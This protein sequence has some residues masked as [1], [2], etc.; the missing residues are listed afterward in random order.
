MSTITRRDALKL[1]S[2]AAALVTTPA[3]AAA[4]AY[5]K[6]TEHAAPIEQWSVFETAFEANSDGNPFASVTLTAS[7]RQGHR[8]L[9][10]DGF[11]DGSGRYKL[12]FM[13]DAV[14]EWSFT[15]MSSLP[16]LHG[17]QGSFHC[18]PATVG[19]HGPVRV[20]RG[21]HFG[22]ADGKPFLPFGT[23]S[24]NWAH[25]SPERQTQTLAALK[26]APFNKLRMCVFPTRFSDGHNELKLA[27][28]ERDA[29]DDFDHTRLNPLFF[30]HLEEQIVALGQQGIEADLILFHPYD[31]WGFAK[32]SAPDDDR[33]LRYVLA[34]FSAYRNV[35]WSLANE[36]DLVRSKTTADFDRFFRI[37]TSSDPYQHLRS[38]HYS[39]VMYDYAAAW[40]T[41]AS[42]QTDAFDQAPR[43][44]AD[45]NKPVLFDEVK[46]EGNVARRWGNLTGEELAHRF[47]LGTVAGCYVTH[48]ETL[49]PPDAP[50]DETTPVSVWTAEGVQLRG[51]SPEMIGFLRSLSEAVA[52]SAAVRAG[53]EAQANPYYLNATTYEADGKTAHA[54]LWYFAE[55]QPLWYEFPL[56]AGPFAAE[57]IDIKARTRTPL[58]GTFSGKS[59]VRLSG[60]PYVAVLFRR[61][62][63]K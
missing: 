44:L 55:H 45:W 43:Y 60:Q 42:L 29:K 13:P 35:W 22:Y 62:N 30:Q 28:F 58:S 57:V 12:R 56:P 14:G 3:V 16:A 46:Y 9:V 61:R 10:V 41:H 40:V 52:E 2:A 32:M 51:R 63:E 49:L 39:K 33:Y 23:T 27:P 54:V 19:N 26:A 24:Y 21:H 11:Y 1:A 47:W 38:I 8:E 6:A 53:W 50:M 48:G 31:A 5:P 18:T 34:R 20:E 37:V 36:F 59:K 25:Q 17:R 7:F 4:A 15:T